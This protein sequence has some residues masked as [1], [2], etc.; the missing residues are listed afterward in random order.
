MS[1]QDRGRAGVYSELYAAQKRLAALHGVDGLSWR[2]IAQLDPFRGISPATLSAVA[3]GRD[4]RR[5]PPGRG[6]LGLPSSDAFVGGGGR[7]GFLP[8]DR[9]DSAFGAMPRLFRTIPAGG[10]V[11]P[12]RRRRLLALSPAAARRQEEHDP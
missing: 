6:G 5:S 1:D 2:K 4:P 3:R 8:W 12:A 7:A 10:G 11:S 9:A